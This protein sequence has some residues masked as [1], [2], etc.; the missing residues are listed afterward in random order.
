MQVPFPISDGATRGRSLVPTA[1]LTDLHANREAMEACLEHARA[2]GATRFAVLGDLVGY[3]ADPGWVVDA[4][5]A[6]A[7]AGA[8][9]VRGNHDDAVVGPDHAAMH[10]AARAAVSWT[11]NR[12]DESQRAWLATLPLTAE[13]PG[14]VLLVHANGWKPGGWEYM[15][16]AFEAQRCLQ[17]VPHRLVLAGHVH[18]PALYHLGP[19]G[20]PA[21]FMP[22]PAVP[23]P[24]SSQRRWVALPGSLGQ[25]RDGVPAACWAMLDDAARTIVFH[26]TPYDNAAAAAKVRAAGLPESLALRLETGR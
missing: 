23:I 26:R 21:G 16:G 15:D 3:G 17:A 6:L 9:V 7:E 13:L 19:T 25:P 8:P 14:G 22:V 18:E 12:L 10:E 20:R 5:R 24:L 11:R 2:A 1:I 4:V